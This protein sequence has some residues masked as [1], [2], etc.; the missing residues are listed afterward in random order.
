MLL[1]GERAIDA[2]VSKYDATLFNHVLAVVVNRWIVHTIGLT[3][4]IK[5][6]EKTTDVPV[7]LV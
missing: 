7:K 4:Q 1:H 2:L 6:T 3:A 5:P